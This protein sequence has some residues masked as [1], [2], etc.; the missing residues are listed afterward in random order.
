M[1]ALHRRSRN[2]PQNP[3]FE[4]PYEPLTRFAVENRASGPD[5]AKSE[6]EKLEM[7]SFF[8]ITGVQ[9]CVLPEEGLFHGFQSPLLPILALILN[10]LFRF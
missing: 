1:V 3:R 5:L 10:E 6:P 8:R 9:T 2:P 7:A 4:P